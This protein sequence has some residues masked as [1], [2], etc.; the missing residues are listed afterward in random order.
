MEC[1][2]LEEAFVKMGY[3]EFKELEP[4]EIIFS[5]D[6]FDQCKKNTCGSFGKNHACPPNAGT[7]TERKQRVLQYEKGYMISKIVPI[8]NRK[9]MMESME[10]V[11]N[12]TKE[13]RK[14]LRGEKALV[15]GAGP[16]TV[17]NEC[18][19]LM[20]DECRFP[21]RIQY[22][23]EGSGIDV[24]RMSMNKKMTYNAGAGNVGYFTLVMYNEN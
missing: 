22:S 1:K 14:I 7:E 8:R 23:M 13:L 3:D 10:I 2:S 12:C 17:C 19:A 20:G 6:V 15:M 5:Q 16:C 24:V 4:S 11:E 9:E 21:D 18:T